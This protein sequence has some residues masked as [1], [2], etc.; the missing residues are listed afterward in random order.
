MRENE[1]IKLKMHKVEEDNFAKVNTSKFQQ[2]T[3]VFTLI[4]CG[5][6]ER[7]LLNFFS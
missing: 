7:V 5:V 3:M 4:I 1:V 6:L 2:M